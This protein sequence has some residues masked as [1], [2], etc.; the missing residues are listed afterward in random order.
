MLNDRGLA[1]KISWRGLGHSFRALPGKQF[2]GLS[3]FVMGISFDELDFDSIGQA[4]TMLQVT[5]EQ[6][7]NIY[8]WETL[9]VTG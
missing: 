2:K 6:S 5:R 9:V 3:S 8:R 1:V 4:G 7:L